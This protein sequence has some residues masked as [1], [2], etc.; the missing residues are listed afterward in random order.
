ML[1][2]ICGKKL[3]CAP[4]TSHMLR[5]TIKF[6]SVLFLFFFSFMVAYAQTDTI[7]IDFGSN[8]VTS[9]IPYNNWTQPSAGGINN[10]SNQNGF[11]SNIGF[12]IFDSFNGVNDAG[13]NMP[14]PILGIDSTASSDS[15][16]GNTI[17]FGGSIEPTAGVELNNLNVDKSYNLSLFASRIATD[18]RQTQYIVEGET[19]DTFLLQVSSNV[20]EIITADLFPDSD[21]TIKIYIS[22]GPENN[23]PFNFYYLGFIRLVCEADPPPTLSLD[24]TFPNGGEYWQ[25]N[26]VPNIEW[27]SNFLGEAILEY[28]ID[29]GNAWTVIDTVSTGE[30][31][32]PWIIPDFPSEECLVR[33]SS[34]TLSDTS[35][36]YFTIDDDDSVCRIVVLGSST[37]AGTGASPI[38]SSWV[39]RFRHAIFQKNTRYVVINLAQGGY[40][41]YHILPTGAP[42]PSNINI[43]PDPFKNMTQALSLDPFA[44]I[45]NM[46]SNDAA[47]SFPVE[48]QLDNFELLYSTAKNVG[49][50]TY[51][52]TT[53]PR[54]F[55]NPTQVEIQ[56]G[57]K[58]SIL[59]IY[60]ENAIDFWSEVATADGWIDPIYDS[61][62]GVHLNNAG[63]RL[64]VERVLETNI[65]EED[66]VP[67]VVNIYEKEKLNLNITAYPN[68]F[69]EILNIDFESPES[70]EVDILVFDT[71]G[72]IWAERRGVKIRNGMN[73]IQFDFDGTDF[74]AM[75]TFYCHAIFRNEGKEIRR[76]FPLAK[77]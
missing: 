4:N 1:V 54:N 39:Y 70:G 46:P 9:D 77:R 42:I 73:S 12:T 32:Y 67:E 30:K 53:Q 29:G 63:H 14:N 58:D 13:T 6:H 20:D 35:D 23:N 49:V 61:G 28:S 59:A 10:L 21:G 44:I 19:M 2:P 26:K 33:I 45:V 3:Y 27:E 16:Y 24:L 22:P 76:S 64:L 55:A 43:T 69:S 75:Q 41:T 71:V 57:T 37:A 38:D 11:P 74:P 8:A 72:R 60:G 65:D 50:E 66:C 62:D 40:T 68:P 31:Y 7:L 51:I 56:V 17:E 48:N 18:N 47:N 34:D 36:N 25:V 52:C 5:E 15:F